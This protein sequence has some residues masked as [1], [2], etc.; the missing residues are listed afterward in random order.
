M[1]VKR[2]GSDRASYKDKIRIYKTKNIYRAL[3][4]IIIIAIVAVIIRVQY[5][6]HVY[7]GYDIV[8]TA[9]RTKSSGAM[10]VRLGSSILTYSKVR[11]ERLATS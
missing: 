2:N 3:L 6:N 9:E 7:T 11:A 5:L 10:D 8:S 1:A 4:I